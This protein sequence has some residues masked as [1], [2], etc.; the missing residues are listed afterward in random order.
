MTVH[1][2]VKLLMLNHTRT[3]GVCLHMRFFFLPRKYSLE[4]TSGLD[5]NVLISNL[6]HISRSCAMWAAGRRKQTFRSVSTWQLL[7]LLNLCFK[8]Y[9]RRKFWGQARKSSNILTSK[10]HSIRWHEK[11]RVPHFGWARCRWLMLCGTGYC[12]QL[13]KCIRR[14]S[15]LCAVVIR[16]IWAYAC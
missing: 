11:R 8:R 12:K 3:D 16:A 1:L 4:G 13:P 14:G 10:V 5:P 9:K 15:E 2:T 7:R 6:H